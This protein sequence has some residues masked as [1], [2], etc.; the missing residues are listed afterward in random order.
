MT[1]ILMKFFLP[2]CLFLFL[3]RHELIS[4]SLSSTKVD[5]TDTASD[6]TVALPAGNGI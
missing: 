2:K 3:V 5:G 1:D 6:I 4:R